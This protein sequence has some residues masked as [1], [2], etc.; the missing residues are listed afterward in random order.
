MMIFDTPSQ[1]RRPIDRNVYHAASGA[2]PIRNFC[3]RLE[4]GEVEPGIVI[5]QR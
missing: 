2:A 3:S 4:I 5:V 1:Y